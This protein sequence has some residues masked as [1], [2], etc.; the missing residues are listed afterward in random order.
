MRGD[1][2]L[3]L[4]G[5]ELSAQPVKWIGQRRIDLTAHPHPE[6]VTPIRIR[7]GAFAE[8]M[9]HRDLLLS[10]DHACSSMAS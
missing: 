9:P 10:P 3:T 8:N 2:V 7:H 6:T 5:E 4:A 1:I